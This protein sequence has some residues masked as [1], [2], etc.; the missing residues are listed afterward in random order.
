MRTTWECARH[1]HDVAGARTHRSIGWRVCEEEVTIATHTIPRMAI[2]ASLARTKRDKQAKTFGVSRS[3]CFAFQHVAQRS[4]FRV[5]RNLSTS[6]TQHDERTERS[7]RELFEVKN[8]TTMF[9]PAL[10]RPM[11][12]RFSRRSDYQTAV[13]GKQLGRKMP[14]QSIS[15]FWASPHPR[16]VSTFSLIFATVSVLRLVWLP[17]RP[18]FRPFRKCCHVP[19]TIAEGK[20]ETH[21]LSHNWTATR[22]HEQRKEE[23]AELAKEN[24]ACM[25]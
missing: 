22:V 24:S 15:Q 23:A 10:V 7:E 14:T 17:A 21:S 19:G 6:V 16:T 1:V 20:E 13:C 2:L 9:C 12:V 11:P 18:A 8:Q 4:L 25:T 3:R 5:C